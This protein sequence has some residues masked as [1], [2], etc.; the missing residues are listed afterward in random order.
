MNE[1]PFLGR[2]GIYIIIFIFICAIIEVGILVFAFFNADKVECNFLW[3]T[4]TDVRESSYS[5]FTK[6]YSECFVND[7]KVNCTEYEQE[8]PDYARNG[9]N[10]VKGICP[11]W[12][13][14]ITIVEC[15][16]RA[17]RNT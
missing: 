15:I 4:F 8:F 10:D 14:N 12:K 11:G 1:E 9:W 3:C 5:S 16:E 13:E 6:T 2:L 7:V 17:M